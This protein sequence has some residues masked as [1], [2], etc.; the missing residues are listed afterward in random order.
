MF[1]QDVWWQ[2]SKTGRVPKFTNFLLYTGVPKS[3]FFSTAKGPPRIVFYPHKGMKESF[4]LFVMLVSLQRRMELT[5]MEKRKMKNCMERWRIYIGKWRISLETWRYIYIYIYIYGYEG[6]S[7]FRTLCV[8]ASA[9][10]AAH[11]LSISCAFARGGP[12]RRNILDIHE[13]FC[14]A[15]P[16]TLF[17]LWGVQNQEALQIQAGLCDLNSN[18]CW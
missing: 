1:S 4:R 17:T 7:P 12:I 2:K 13:W 6:V 9:R 16:V 11:V 5:A 18:R 14:L 15:M 8:F 10:C 3:I